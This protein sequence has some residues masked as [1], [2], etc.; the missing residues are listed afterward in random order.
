MKTPMIGIVFLLL[1]CIAMACLVTG[2]KVGTVGNGQVDAI[3]A[4]VFRLA[5]G[6]ALDAKPELSV[7]A[8]AVSNALLTVMTDTDAVDLEA[9]DRVIDNRVS[10][11]NLPP[12]VQAAFAGLVSDIRDRVI[13]HIGSSESDAA[14]ASVVVRD[15]VQI[16]NDV[17][18]ARI[19]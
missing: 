10:E 18:T 3:E 7:P 12:D 17:S 5:V 4:S 15:L 19:I 6:A 1:C 16:V 2:C 11:L 14:A 8:S 13:D 9:V